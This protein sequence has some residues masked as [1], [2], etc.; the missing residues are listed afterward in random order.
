MSLIWAFWA[1]V[2]TIVLC[3]RVVPT[4]ALLPMLAILGGFY[5]SLQHEVIHRH[6]TP[7]DRLNRLLVVVPLQLVFPFERYRET[8]LQHHESDL[9][10]PLVDPES[11]YVSSAAWQSARPTTR[12]LLVLNRTLVGRL[13]IGPAL[14]M[15]QFWRSEAELVRHDRNAAQLWAKHVVAVG[16][17]LTL[18]RFSPMPLWVFVLG[19]GWGG[20][21]VTMLRSFAEHCAFYS[22]DRTA[23]V[24]SNRA[25]GLLFLNNNLHLAHHERPAEP[26]YRLPKVG[27]DLD[28]VQRSRE[29][30]SYFSGYGQIARRYGIRRFCQVEY[31]QGSDS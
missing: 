10:D 26:W 24:E 27:V 28:V 29:A 22:T 12:K 21:A 25:F 16:G 15:A 3:A 31:P 1:S 30:G 23:V 11:F 13:T 2:V 9:T 6:P 20:L 5:G 18:I 4:L 14:A 19:F 17:V 7:W 8:H